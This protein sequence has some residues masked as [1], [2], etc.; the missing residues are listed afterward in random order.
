MKMTP[1]RTWPIVLATSIV[2]VG[3]G[4]V[5]DLTKDRVARSETAVRQAQQNVGNAEQGALELQKARDHLDQAR[6]A[7]NDKKE[8]PAVRHAQQAELYAELAVAR[9]QSA[10]ARRAAEELQASIRTLRQEAERGNPT[11]TDMQ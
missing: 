3:C 4:G 11:A 8:E 10:S 6:R 1:V 7:L 5:S 9:T 2:F